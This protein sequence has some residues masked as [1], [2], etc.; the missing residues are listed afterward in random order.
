MASSG[1]DKNLLIC[2]LPP[3]SKEERVEIV[4]MEK[5]EERIEEEEEEGKNLSKPL[6]HNPKGLKEEVAHREKTQV[7]LDPQISH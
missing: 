2:S 4:N 1:N 6:R 3:F 7:L 5:R